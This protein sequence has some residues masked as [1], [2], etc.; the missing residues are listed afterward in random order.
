MKS[1][2]INWTLTLVLGLLAVVT[3]FL[4]VR[5]IILA[6]EFRTLSTQA[7]LANNSL[8]QARSLAND[9]GLYNQ[10]YPSPELTKILAT[11]QGRPA[12]R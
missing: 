6:H 5:T 9:V 8:L 10:K 1:D 12:A 2:L 11:V 7:A 4:A 3:V